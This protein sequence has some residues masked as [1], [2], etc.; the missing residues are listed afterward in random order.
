MIEDRKITGVLEQLR[1]VEPSA[2]FAARSKAAILAAP[3]PQKHGW[4]LY[5]L[6][7]SLSEGVGFVLSVGLVSI[8]AALFISVPKT[9][10]PVVGNRLPG[11]ETAALVNDVDA[12]VK[13]ID[14]HI[15]EAQLFS[16]AA[17]K[18]NSA[19]KEISK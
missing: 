15:Q 13:D 14:I 18:A 7:H 2:D 8:I 4:G 17:E 12:A 3:R 19:L 1:R 5:G 6:K 11:A 9:F 16:T 10:G